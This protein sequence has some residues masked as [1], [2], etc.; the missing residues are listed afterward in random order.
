M[1]FKSTMFRLARIDGISSTAFFGAVSSDE[2]VLE[3]SFACNGP[4]GGVKL[5]LKTSVL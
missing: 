5:I 2:Y 1:S 4:Q 3:Y